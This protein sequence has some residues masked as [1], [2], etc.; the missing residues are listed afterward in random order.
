VDGVLDKL[1]SLLVREQIICEL[2]EDYNTEKPEKSTPLVL[3]HQHM[4]ATKQ[5]VDL[6]ET[7]K[8][9]L[10]NQMS[11][12]ACRIAEERFL[13][14]LIKNAIDEHLLLEFTFEAVLKSLLREPTKFNHHYFSS[15]GQALSSIGCSQK[16]SWFKLHSPS[17]VTTK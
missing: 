2:V 17:N 8:D 7:H 13:G 9:L 16:L 15:A 4:Q 11:E 6:K 3:K 5:E 10:A 12:Y 14:E 1:L